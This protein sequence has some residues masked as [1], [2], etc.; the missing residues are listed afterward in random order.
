[1]AVLACAGV[2]VPCQAQFNGVLDGLKNRVEDAVGR[3]IGG[4]QNDARPA[5]GGE[6]HRALHINAGF[7]FVRGATSIVHDDFASAAVGAMPRTWK[8]NGSGDIVTVDGIPGNWL[9]LQDFATYKLTNAPSLPARFTVEFDIV[10]SADTSRDLN[11]LAFGFAK[12][13]SVRAYIQDAYNEGAITTVQLGYSGDG[14][15]SSSATGYYHSVD[16][17]MRSTVNRVIHVSIAVDGD[18]EKVYLDRDKIADAKLFDGNKVKYF[19]ISAPVDT[20]HG[21]K[22]LFGNFRIDGVP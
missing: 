5:D 16:R 3:Q 18:N 14:S 15:V 12:D 1:M 2:T 6:P 21:A 19:F 22:F 17:D 11:S 7:D 10:G 13:N 8:T 9:A 4:Q 20:D